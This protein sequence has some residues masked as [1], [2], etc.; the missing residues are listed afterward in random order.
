[1]TPTQERR[2]AE[3]VLATDKPV[4]D[5]ESKSVVGAVVLSSLCPGLGHFYLGEP[6][7]AAVWYFLG[8]LLPFTAPA[9]AGAD[10][11]TENKILLGEQYHQF[12]IEARKH[13]VPA[14]G[15]DIWCEVCG[16]KIRSDSRFCSG[17]GRSR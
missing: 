1:M 4:L 15:I 5:T 9:V 10:A 16:A 12:K 13:A 7:W 11:V 8:L 2:Y 6:G 14:V 17:C 3:Y